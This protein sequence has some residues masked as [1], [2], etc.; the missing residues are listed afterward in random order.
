MEEGGGMGAIIG[1]KRGRARRPG[2]GGKRGTR[3]MRELGEWGLEQN[4]GGDRTGREKERGAGD[5][6]GDGGCGWGHELGTGNA[7][8]AWAGPALQLT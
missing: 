5:E 1:S 8:A 2:K 3:H 7:L 4:E 6:R